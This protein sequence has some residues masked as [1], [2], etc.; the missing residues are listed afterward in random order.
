MQRCILLFWSAFS[1]HFHKLCMMVTIHS[2]L[3]LNPET[4]WFQTMKRT[5]NPL[6][7]EEFQFMLEEPPLEEK[8]HVEV[9][10]KRGRISFLSKVHIIV[11]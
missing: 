11:P 2:T 4:F 9:L 10:S 7:N 3:L 8:I 5:R 6:W 1:S